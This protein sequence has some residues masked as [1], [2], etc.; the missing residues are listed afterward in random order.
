DAQGVRV[1]GSRTFDTYFARVI[2]Q[3]TIKASTGASAVT[4]VV[5]SLCAPGTGCGLFP[6]TVP[7]VTSNCDNNGTLT[8]GVGDWPFLGEADMNAHHEEIIPLRKAQNPRI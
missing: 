2:G 1:G 3:N 4:R 5:T 7:Y 8:P 6:I